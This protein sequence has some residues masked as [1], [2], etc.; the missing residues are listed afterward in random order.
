MQ[1]A[2]SFDVASAMALIRA[3][4]A[5]RHTEAS[6]TEHRAVRLDSAN[7]RLESNKLESAV[8]QMRAG[9]AAAA[10]AAAATAATNSEL[11]HLFGRVDN[12]TRWKRK[13]I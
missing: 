2:N 3:R 9:V 13:R 6:G 7:R 1:V 10:A 11:D 12:S 8:H 5:G 4:V